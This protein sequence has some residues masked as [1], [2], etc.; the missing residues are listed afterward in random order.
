[1]SPPQEL[2][3]SERAQTLLRTLVRRYI[4][5]GRPIGSRS[6]AQAYG[7]AVSPATVRNALV[8]LEELGYLTAPHTSAGRVP[9]DRGLRVYVDHL[10]Q[11]EPVTAATVEHLRRRL[12]RDREE[13]GDELADSASGLLSQLTRLAGVVTLPRRERAVLRH[14]DF[15]PLS[16]RRVLAI[17]VV[18]QRDV[19]HRVIEADRAFSEA[20]LQRLANYLNTEY[21]GAEL[22]Q[23]RDSLRAAVQAER[24]RLDALLGSVAEVAGKALAEEAGSEDYVV[25]GQTNLMGLEELSDVARLRRLFEAFTQK[26]DILHLLDRCARPQGVQVYIGREAG[27]AAFDG[28]SL[29]T[30]RYAVEGESAGVLG[31]IG[32]TRMAYGQVVPI[33]DVTAR[34]VGAALNPLR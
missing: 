14:V 10:L 33:V 5:E 34:L 7:L 19:Q 21:A 25:A 6:L 23:V 32:P 29:V 17:L 18:N 31:V 30:A 15:L 9:T 27:H 22:S 1:M 8:D 4:E 2:E 13:G 28:M 26:Q 12:V 16:G 3:L 24:E 11:V 20:E